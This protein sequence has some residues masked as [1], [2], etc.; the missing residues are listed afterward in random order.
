MGYEII[1]LSVIYFCNFISFL[2]FIRVILSWFI[3][4]VR[5]PL[6]ALIFS[7]TDPILL[8]IKRLLQNSPLGGSGMMLDFSPL[9]AFLLI[10]I[11]KSILLSVIKSFLF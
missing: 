9:L 1:E 2:I 7:L 5:N 6:I 4:N 11:F 3:V 10:E 8:P